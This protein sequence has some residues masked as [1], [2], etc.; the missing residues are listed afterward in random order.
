M[1]SRYPH[2]FSRRP[3]PASRRARTRAHLARRFVFSPRPELLEERLTL[4]GNITI[5]GVSV[6]DSNNNPLTVVNAGE[7]VYIHADF[8]TENLPDNASYRVGYTVNGLTL[9]TGYLTWGAG[10]SGAADWYAYW[11]TFLA[12]PGTNQVTVSVDPD[13]SVPE[14][15]YTDNTMSLTFNAVTP[16]VGNMTYTVAQMRAAYGINSIPAFGSA[17]ADGSGQTIALDEAGNEP[18]ILT[19]L[20]GFD[21][22][23][24]LT[25]GSTETLY[26]QYGP[27]SSFVN[28][29][30]QDGTNITADIAHS[31]SNGVPAEDP[32][33][34]WEGE[35]TLDVEWAHAI[36]PGAKIDIIEVNDD[37]NWPTNLLAGDAL[38]ASLPGVSAISNSWGLTEWSG[39]TAYDSSTFVTPRGHTGVTFL[40]ASNDNGADVYPS[41]PSNPA[42]SAGNDGYY[43]A[44]SP[45]VVSVGGTQLTVN[46]DG[47]GG[48]TGWSYPAPASTVDHGSVSYT[49]SG[50]WVAQSGGFSGTYSTAAGGS[51]SSA[52]WTISITPANTGWGTE[53]SA[54]WTASPTNATNAT[55]TIYDGTQA[56]GTILGTVV[57][58][59]AEAPAG[60][61]AGGSRFQELGVF[62][63]TLNATGDGTLTV[64]LNARSANGTVVADALGA[65]QAWASTG[66]PTRFESEPSYQ[67]P[68]QSTGSRTTPDVSFDASQ[69][70]G[71]DV[72]QNGQLGYDA[73][74]TSLSSPCW[75]GLIAI[76]NQGRVFSGGST[77]NSTANP[78][79]TLQAL[80]SL[81]ASDFY[82]ITSGYNGFSAGAGYDE[83]TGRG[84]PIANLLVPDLASYGLPTRL[85]ITTPLPASVTA[86]STFGL[87]V[88]VEDNLGDQITS[89]NGSVTIALANN[90]GDGTLGGPVTE[91]VVNG[92][93]TFSGLTLDAAGSGY[94]LEA[95]SGSLTSLPS[96]NF[97][98]SPAAASQLVIHTQP[99]ARATAG[100]AFATQ[101]VI[102]EE[103]QYGNLETGDNSTVVTAALESGTG[104]LQG[105]A[106]ATV[107]GGVATFTNL[108]DDK[109]ETIA[110][111]FTSGS[112]T[113]ATSADIAISPAAASKLVIQT[114][115]SATATAGQAFAIQ[116]V[117]EETDQY[118]NLETSDNST[119]VTAGLSSGAGQLQGAT[120]T[121]SGGVATFTRLAA[122]TA[123]SLTLQ[124]TGGGV[125]SLP[126]R[127]IVVS[128]AA[129][130]QL[131]VARQPS[132]TAT[133][134]Q[135]FAVQPVIDEEDRYGNLETAD[136]STVVAVAL[137]SGAGPLRGTVTATVTGGVATFLNLADNMA[138]TIALAFTSGSLTRVTSADIAIG[139]AAASQLI[140]TQQPSATGTAGQSFAT[141]PMVQEA[142]RFGNVVTSDSTHTVTAA[143]TG[144]ASLQGTN[145]TVT[146]AS[147]VAA[148]TGLSYDKAETLALTFTTNA[149]GV[150][151]ITSRTI[152]VS[153]AAASQLV[154]QRQPSAT[155]TAGQAL[156]TQPVIEE[157][158]PYGNLE[159]GDS[160]TVVTASLNSGAGPLQGTT[161]TVAG[162]V[163][164]FTSLAD[165]KAGSIALRFSSGSLTGATSTT[166]LISPAAARALVVQ[167]QPS[168]TATAGQAFGTQPVLDEV[169][170]YG[171]LE[172]SDNTTLVTAS[173]A[174]GTGPL[175]GPVSA[176]VSGGV[177]T[178]ANLADNLAETITL[179][180]TSG[181]LTAATTDPIAVSPAAAGKLVIHTQPAATAT[182]GQALATQP[183]LYEED[184]FGNLETG[185]NSTVITAAPSAGAAQLAGATAT[186]RG[187]VATFTNLADDTAGTMSL[188]FTGGGLTAGPS[189]S[190]TVSPA[191]AAKL[192]IQTQ[193]SATATA[194][195]PFA[196]QPVI[197]VE[198]QYGNLETGDN[199]GI[200]T[201]ALENSTGPL[202]G[203]ITAII[204]GGVADFA[205]LA[206]T[207]AQTISL[208]FTGVGL[209]PAASGTI[210]VSPA[211]ATQLVVT[212][213]PPDPITPGQA[214]PLVVSAEDSYG[215][216]SPSFHGSVTVTLANDPAWTTTVQAQ[217]GVAT[218]AGLTVDSAAQGAAIQATA[219]GLAAAATP[220]L[221]VI[222]IPTPTPAPTII[223]AL[224]LTSQKKNKKG[225]PAGKPVF[226]GFVL[227]Y[228]TAMNPATA[229]LT[230]DYQ[231]D[232]A[233]I[234]RVKKKQT[235]VFQPVDVTA[236]YNPATQAVTL[237]IQGKP[238]FT[239]GGR[240]QV[241]AASP[242]GVSSAAGV[243]LDANDTVLTILP[244]ARGITPSGHSS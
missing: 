244:K 197:D 167:T 54:T 185:D 227:D 115:P 183:V 3:S 163:A 101:P 85:A 188:R 160:S 5:T 203:T 239:A 146:L 161:A 52:A 71:V 108:A 72:Y 241:M 38:A 64:V 14:T 88:A 33:G 55:Y 125:T 180:F 62:F 120:A 242:N 75:A 91:P 187:G 117:I 157:E 8:T 131:I 181:G 22:A 213:P 103:D 99:S 145:L 206:D 153:P 170:Q 178:F 155:A 44:T 48:E 176:T 156:A 67:L 215:N 106:T 226:V 190:L 142:D 219:S 199:S 118:G 191:A 235:T 208:Q 45:Y 234:K 21:Q 27:A 9:D 148:F 150:S 23:M 104:P 220:P 18:S 10:L 207:K 162:G 95:S 59:Q 232:S 65:A 221:N 236:A 73:F 116:P 228:S 1:F 204:S 77:F 229:G 89:Y 177:A 6:V 205:D 231:V 179:K 209:S 15:T 144:T 171:N 43:P 17:A 143:S 53:V 107:S 16:A 173:L 46:N 154:I 127:T 50:P 20:D 140:I 11:G 184:P 158:D 243:P 68:F 109:A 217:N 74:G 61:A 159:T 111:A 40:T 97:A 87:T 110:L 56:S 37:A 230:A 86:G 194:G 240:I 100:Q 69:E 168:A 36:A 76:A 200:V 128:P 147:G 79:Q 195:Q 135:A 122:D 63:P 152:T 119:V 139:P 126:T 165:D 214:F 90:P 223:G 218:F 82:D 182:A 39:E 201:A 172:T 237:T 198:D 57:V 24:S 225:K 211:A 94:A 222:P 32:T 81:P 124:F 31:G 193:P 129:A 121:V 189:T 186:V 136:N 174:S 130:S 96:N 233:V 66:G 141:Q 78:M 212:T 210:T 70:S 13:H 7:W 114:Q 216:V 92:V 134:G 29:Y 105:T 238:K 175:R 113:R 132:A 164:T 51:S 25:T 26:Q 12:T 58:N 28:V 34:H 30:N 202:Q 192:A 102:D 19:D 112:L 41:P 93:A 196:T 80:Y 224:V 2:G 133:A 84:S 42:P 138:E 169:D 49:Q 151:P 166:I 149:G 47:Y 60:T 137:Q 123:E 35:E 98:V 4:T 83:V